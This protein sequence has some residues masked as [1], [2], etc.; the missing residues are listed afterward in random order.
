MCHFLAVL[1]TLCVETE[2]NYERLRIGGLVITGLLLV[3]GIS[4]LLC[5]KTEDLYCIQRLLEH[6]IIV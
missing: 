5:N 1:F 3:G 2:A 4:V 6:R